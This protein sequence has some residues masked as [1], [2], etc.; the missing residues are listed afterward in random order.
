MT[1]MENKNVGFAVATSATERRR[2]YA[3]LRSL[4]N[5]GLS[6]DQFASFIEKG[7][8]NI[9]APISASPQM[10]DDVDPDAKRTASVV[11]TDRIFG[12]AIFRQH[13]E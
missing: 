10:L 1:L 8:V 6:A 13:V 5:I 9:K 7:F 4:F 11:D 12:Q 3:Q 2:D